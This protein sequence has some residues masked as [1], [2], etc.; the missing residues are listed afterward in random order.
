MA[1]RIDNLIPGSLVNL[2]FHPG[3]GSFTKKEDVTPE[4]AFFIKIEGAGDDRRAT[5][6]Q[7]DYM[8]QPYTWQAYRYK[9]RWAYGTGADKLSLDSVVELGSDHVRILANLASLVD[10][11]K[12][13][14][15]W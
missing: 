13:F 4:E 6:V 1:L 5:F 15:T 2:V 8:N 14:R 9:G 11:K 12:L 10:D 7:L 3:I